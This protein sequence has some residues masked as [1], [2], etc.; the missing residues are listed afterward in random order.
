MAESERKER[1]RVE[2]T[3]G[4]TPAE[5]PPTEQAVLEGEGKPSYDELRQERDAALVASAE[6]EDKFLRAR[7]ETENTRR[8]AEIDLANARKYA[9]ESFATELLPVRDSLELAKTVDLKQP[10]VVQKVIEGLDLTLKLMET[11]F[12]KFGLTVVD[13][14]GEKFDPERHQ[15]MTMVESDQVPANHV[16]HVMQKGYLL[17]NRLLRP[18]MVVV[19]KGRPAASGS[20]SAS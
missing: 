11:A 16:A 2:P 8:R 20:P 7:A 19:S 6:L 1:P 18:A 12:G 4:E 13:P 3:L 14:A 17:N 10:D 5:Q 9:L 15:A